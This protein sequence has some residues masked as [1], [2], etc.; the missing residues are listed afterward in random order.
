MKGLGLKYGKVPKRTPLQAQHKQKR[1]ELA[2]NWIVENLV[3]KKVVFTDEKRF[4]FDGP[5][6]WFSWYD[7]FN[8]P[9]RIKRHLGGGSVM[10][11]GATLPSGELIVHRLD[12]K[13]NSTVYTQ[14]LDKNVIPLLKSKFGEQGYIFQ[15]DKCSVHVSK[16]STNYFNRRKIKLLDWVAYS[17]DM[18]IQENV[19]SM[20]SEKVY[21][22]KQYFNKENLWE[23]IQ[24]AVD[25][26][27][28][29]EKAKVKSLF[30]KYNNRLLSVIKNHG[31]AIPY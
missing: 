12:G 24:D 1:F 21:E 29:R 8:P 22:K 10:V 19:W 7:P 11:W 4:S 31:N 16:E 27:N 25:E 26:I 9:A 17:P 5:D 6:N 14:M 30:E 15:Q 28:L 2:E 23:S 13:V 18:N 3:T 20:I